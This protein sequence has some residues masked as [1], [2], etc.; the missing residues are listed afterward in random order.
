VLRRDFE[1]QNAALR[2][3]IKHLTDVVNKLGRGDQT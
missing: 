3:E 2:A 1:Q